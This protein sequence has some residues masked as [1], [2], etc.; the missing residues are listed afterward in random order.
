MNKTDIISKDGSTNSYL[1]KL[2]IEN[3]KLN[4]NFR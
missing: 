3:S 2:A 4:S 1:R